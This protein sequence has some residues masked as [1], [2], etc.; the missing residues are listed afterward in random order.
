MGLFMSD[1]CA[2]KVIEQCVALMDEE[3][4]QSDSHFLESTFAK[5]LN[6]PPQSF[7]EAL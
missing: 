7:P 3:A 6:E 5:R 2:D 1:S 4:L